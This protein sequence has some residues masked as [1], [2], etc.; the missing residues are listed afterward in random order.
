MIEFYMLCTN[1][2]NLSFD[3][4]LEL[5][6]VCI[7]QVDKL[8]TAIDSNSFIY[9]DYSLKRDFQSNLTNKKGFYVLVDRN[10]KK[11]TLEERLI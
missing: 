5:Q 2:S 4:L 1:F 7:K 11:S 3:T 6:G 8:F 9:D 10:S